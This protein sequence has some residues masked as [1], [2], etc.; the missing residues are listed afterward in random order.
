MPFWKWQAG[1][2]GETDNA[3]K[4]YLDITRGKKDFKDFFKKY[5]VSMVLWPTQ[6]PKGPFVVLEEKFGSKLRPL[7]KIFGVEERKFNF[8]E[9]L[10]KDGWSEIYRDNVAVIYIKIL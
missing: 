3:M 4:D 2:D 7:Y 6:K 9:Q 8:L 5:D 10:K 1:L